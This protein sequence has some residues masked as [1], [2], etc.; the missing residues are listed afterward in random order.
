MKLS[1]NWIKDYIDLEGITPG[2][3][4]HALT[5]SGSEVDSMED[6]GGDKVM[7]MEITSNRPDCLNMIGLA[8]EASAVFDRDL[9]LPG[10]TLEA[11]LVDKEIER[12]ECVIEAADLCPFYTARVVSGVS[13]RACGGEIKEKL[14]AL[15]MRPVNNIVDITN[16]CLMETGQPL[17]AFDLD[18]I[19]GG[20]VYIRK[21]A[22]G[23][24]ITTIDD[25]ERELEEGMLV[26]ADSSGPV[27]VAGVM[28]GKETEVTESTENILLE[29]AY[30][31]PLSIRRTARAL[32]L[33][34][35][36]SYR[37]E[38][39][40]DK[41][42]VIPSSDRAASLIIAEAGGKAGLMS[43]SG[44][45]EAPGKKIE[46]D[47]TGAERVL[48]V[49]LQKARTV[50]ILERL[51]AEVTEKKEGGLS[52][53]VP[54]FR[55]DLERE[56]DLVE[57][58]ARV[59]GYDNIPVTISR[60]VPSIERKNHSRRVLDRIRRSLPA[61]GM[62]EIMSYSLIG[63]EAAER[64]KSIVSGEV[65][66]DNPLSEEHKVLTPHLLDGMLKAVSHNLNRQNTDLRL[67]EIGKIYSRAEGKTPFDEEET[68]CAAVTGEVD[69]GWQT[70]SRPADIFYLKGVVDGMLA[71][72]KLKAEYSPSVIKGLSGAAE[73]KLS[74]EKDPIGVIAGV[75]PRMLKEYNI[76][77]PVFAV[78]LRLRRVMEKA[79][80]EKHYHS[81]PKFP[82]SSRDVSVLCVVDTPA[83]EI[84]KVISAT[85]EDLIR[86]V[87]LVDIYE[88]DQVPEGKKSLTY[89]ITYGLDTRTLREEEI[90]AVHGKIKE[91]LQKDLGVSFR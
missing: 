44:Q 61:F 73:I 28:G 24:K 74:G 25:V 51:G 62:S 54:S 40:V 60:F 52:V 27:A 31:D 36:S 2:E 84:K 8:R 78:Q 9:K 26:I 59:F 34:S 20:R 17:H 39:G 11:N 50:R 49:S 57:E 46:F 23:E 91:A 79:V 55:E 89:S 70:D 47:I 35:D 58:V 87:R 18:K 5:M 16:F 88:G 71:P 76:Q 83:G 33:S 72:L 42:S 77:Q 75:S 81:I 15:G 86:D 67:F 19:K 1:Y 13:V 30:F 43:V 4:A 80:L 41:A 64:F 85:G 69:R 90:E 38:R 21:A 6:A 48:G 37:F 10:M 12:R 7:E 32:G 14:S 45:L 56:I 65:V 66:L 53:K 63:Q 29:S 3:L 82:F 22:K 68:F